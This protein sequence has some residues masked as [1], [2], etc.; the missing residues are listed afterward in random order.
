[1]E[2][3]LCQTAITRSQRESLQCMCLF[4]TPKKEQHSWYFCTFDLLYYDR[5]KI[6]CFIYQDCD[7]LMVQSIATVSTI[8]TT[9]WERGSPQI[10]Q[11]LFGEKVENKYWSKQTKTQVSIQKEIKIILWSYWNVLEAH[12]KSQLPMYICWCLYPTNIHKYETTP[13]RNNSLKNH[14]C[15]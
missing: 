2:Y 10:G 7:A 3:Q 9:E 14:R 8:I 1:M 6:Y 11:M 13:V 15:V 5:K 12:F 4:K